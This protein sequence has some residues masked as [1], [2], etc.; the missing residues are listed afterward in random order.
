MNKPTNFSP[1]Q[2]INLIG[3]IYQVVSTD[4]HTP[5]YQG[6]WEDCSNYT[7]DVFLTEFHKVL[8]ESLPSD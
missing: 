6:S 8:K 7:K 1:I 5:Y 2:I 4:I 3:E